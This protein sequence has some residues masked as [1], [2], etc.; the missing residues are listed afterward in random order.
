MKVKWGPIE[1]KS[2]KD[3]IQK[4]T[5]LSPFLLL[6][7][8]ALVVCASFW[9]GSPPDEPVMAS[10]PLSGKTIVLDAGHGGF[11]AGAHGRTTGAFESPIN[12]S[13][14]C[15]LR[16]E[17]QNAGAKIIMTREEEK[18][19]ASTK[20]SDMEKRR[21]IISQSGID[22]AISIHLNCFTDPQPNGP[23]VFYY[24]GSDEGIR[25]AQAIQASLDNV[26]E[27]KPRDAK[28]GDFYVLRAG[29]TTCVLVECGFLSNPVDEA[30]LVTEIHQ[31]KVAIA[32]ANGI[33]DYFTEPPVAPSESNVL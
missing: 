23:F 25:L 10:G 18:A 12:L 8:M 2:K 22:A 4:N 19:L 20:R 14:T 26:L 29:E 9:A 5:L 21:N 13:I 27:R 28:P 24:Q 7:L 1:I 6:A 31:K 30:M 32:I 3:K 17:L 33:I 16:D 15:F 11:D